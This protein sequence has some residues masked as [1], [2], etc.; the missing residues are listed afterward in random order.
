MM[1]ACRR[2]A[3]VYRRPV[4]WLR[5]CSRNKDDNVS[6]RGEVARSAARTVTLNNVSQARL[7]CLCVLSPKVQHMVY[8]SPGKSLPEGRPCDGSMVALPIGDEA[9]KREVLL[10]YLATINA[11]VAIAVFASPRT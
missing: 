9:G 3:V 1:S 8:R 10:K 2:L 7:M 11:L 4:L 6:L 5:Y